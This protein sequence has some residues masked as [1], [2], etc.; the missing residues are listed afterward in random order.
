MDSWDLNEQ[1]RIS[2]NM[3]QHMSSSLE[4]KSK[5][6]QHPPRRLGGI[7]SNIGHCGANEIHFDARF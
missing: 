2:Y 7:G 3:L 6:R 5:L 1:L 4:C